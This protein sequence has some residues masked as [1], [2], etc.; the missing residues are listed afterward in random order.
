MSV[1][2]VHIDHDILVWVIERIGKTV[3]EYVLGNS[4]F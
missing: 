3:D 1:A 4:K 2:R